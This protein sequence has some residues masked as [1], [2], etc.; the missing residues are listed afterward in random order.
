MVGP[1]GSGKSTLARLLYRFY[2]V[3]AGVISIDGQNIA[4]CAQNSLRQNISIVPQDSVLFNES[5]R[6]NIEYGNPRASQAALYEAI[7]LANLDSL[8]ASL[9]DG[10]NTVVGERGLKLSGGE[11]QRIAIARAILKK[12]K[13]IIF[14]EA[15]SSLDSETEAAVMQAIQKVT[16]NV[17]S[18]IIAHRLSTIVNADSIYVLEN[19]A[20]VEQGTHAELLAHNRLYSNLWKLQQRQ[21]HAA[22]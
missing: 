20:V 16:S 19:G 13:I 22:A 15:T 4:Q 18:L 17:T 7:A 12:P 11:V 6:F 1:S 8:I 3:N 21:A 2:D 14:D 10:L 9:P 5:I